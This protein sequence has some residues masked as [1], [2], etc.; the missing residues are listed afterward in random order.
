MP[1]AFVCAPLSF[2]QAGDVPYC[3]Q[4]MKRVAIQPSYDVPGHYDYSCP[5]CPLVIFRDGSPSLSEEVIRERIEE[6]RHDLF[7]N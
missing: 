2:G 7:R 5:L 4:T 3:K 1:S 6:V